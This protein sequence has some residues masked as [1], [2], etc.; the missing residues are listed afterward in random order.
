MNLK[1]NTFLGDPNKF[2]ADVERHRNATLESVRDAVARYLDTRSRLLVRF[3]V[4]SS[5]RESQV[6][7]DRSKEPPLGADRPFNA[8]E[9]KSAKLENGMEILVVERNDLP[10]LAVTLATRAGSAADPAGKEGLADMTVAMMKR[11]TKTKDAL[12]I[13][14]ALGDLGASV[15]AAAGCEHASLSLEVLKRNL[16]PALTILADIVRDPA[17]SDTE[18]EREREQRLDTLAQESQDATAIAVR[19]GTMLIFGADHPYG[20]PAQGLPQ[21]IERITRDDLAWFYETYWKPGSS[22]LIFIGDI[23]LDEATELANQNFGLWSGGAAPSIQIPAPRPAGP[24]KVYLVDR[25]DA[26]QTFV[27]QILPAPPRESDD[28]YAMS[29]ADMVWGGGFST[30][31]NMNLREDKGYSYGAYSYPLFYSKAGAWSSQAGIQTDKTKEALVEFDKELRYLAGEKPISDEELLEAKAKRIRG[32][33]QQFESLNQI[34]GQIAALWVYS[35]PMTEMQREPTQ[36]DKTTLDAVN[37]VAS[38]YAA[39]V[40][41]TTLLVGDLS[42]IEAGV[43]ELNLGEVIVLDVEGNPVTK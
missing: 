2:E 43:R 22:A 20:R 5:G 9:V 35:L 10:K 23:T 34:A 27:A 21:T 36:L 15:T 13:E 28:Y 4:E 16:T 40:T 8:P 11:G 6:E 38:K 7:F 41:A 24:G 14:E 29:L 30:R 18:A 17:F 33:A 3:R 32:Y 25:Q 19:V 31:L 42:E 26:A 12:E 37:A 39:P 1:Y